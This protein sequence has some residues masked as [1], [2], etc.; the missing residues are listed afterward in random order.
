MWQKTEQAKRRLSYSLLR[1]RLP[2]ETMQAPLIFDF[3]ARTA[4]APKLLMGHDNGVITIPVEEGDDATREEHHNAMGEPYRTLLGHF[5]HEIGH[6][7]WDLLLRDGGQ[8]ESFRSL[9]GDER[10]DCAAALKSYYDR[11]VV[12]PS[13]GFISAYATSHPWEDFAKTFAHYL[14]IADTLETARAMGVSLRPFNK[15]E[16]A[17]AFDP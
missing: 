6:Y 12:E 4:V 16:L 17:V 9:F 2:L 15:T 8:Q 1:P 11:G 13:D 10:T 14:H 7:D 5:R 3:V